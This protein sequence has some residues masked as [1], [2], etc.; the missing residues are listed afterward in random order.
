MSAPSSCPNGHASVTRQPTPPTAGLRPPPGPRGRKLRNFRRRTRNYTDFMTELNGEYGEIVSYE[1]PFMKCCAVFSADLIREVLVRQQ[2]N[3][4]PWFPGGLSEILKYG[5]V[6]LHQGEEQ[7]RRSELMTAAFSPERVEV[8]AEIIVEKAAELRD[9][10]RQA[11]V[12]DVVEEME[13]FTWDALVSIILGRHLRVPRHLGED[14]LDFQKLYLILDMLPL[15]GWLKRL[16]LP[17]FR[18]GYRSA[19]ALDRVM[20]K[21]MDRARDPSHSGDDI[22]SHYVR[23]WERGDRTLPNDQAIRDEMIILLSAFVD[24]PTSALAFAIYQLTRD[25]GIRRR[26]EEEIDE[27]LGGREITPADYDKFPYLTA[28]LSEILRLEPPAP[29]LLPK[30]TVEDCALGGYLIPAG[31][32]VHVGMRVLHHEPAYWKNADDFRPERWLEEPPP[33]PPGVP[34]HA[35]IP[36]GQGPHACRGTEV[37]KRLFVF[38]MAT[39]LQ[40][41]RI[42]PLS[43]APPRRND[44]AVGVVGPMQAAVKP[45]RI[46][47]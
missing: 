7:R 43:S 34:E 32:L 41:L 2:F 45:R 25:T 14:V 29:V 13:R 11:D 35:Y 16:P 5:A 19:A 47:P 46:Q 44:T 42:D 27:V 23:A 4:P 37:A 30:E 18:R 21:A 6:A 17:A 12:I 33:G 28:I 38:G 39:L 15:R 8:Y 9:R 20:F 10:C 31:T 3:F 36:F 22:I 1:L 26:I 24:A 40:S